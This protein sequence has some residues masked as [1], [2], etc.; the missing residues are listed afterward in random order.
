M[1]DKKHIDRLFQEKFKD[2]EAKPNANVWVNIQSQLNGSKSKDKVIPLWI[3]FAGIAALLML[4]FGLGNSFLANSTTEEN[5]KTVVETTTNEASKTL[6]NL[7]NKNTTNNT[8]DE[9]NLINTKASNKA[10]NTSGTVLQEDNSVNNSNISKNNNNNKTIAN[11]KVSNKALIIIDNSVAEGN[12]KNSKSDTSR[13]DITNKNTVITQKTI[14]QKNKNTVANLNNTPSQLASSNNTA[15]QQKLNTTIATQQPLVTNNPQSNTVLQEIAEKVTKNTKL[16]EGTTKKQNTTLD[17]INANQTLEGLAKTNNEKEEEKTNMNPKDEDAQTPNPLEEALANTEDS[18]EKEEETVLNK[19][20][21]NANVAPVYYN[22]FGK[23]SHIHDQFIENEKNGEINTS[24]G[25]NVGYVLNKKL[26]VR[27]G[28][29]KL[30]LSYDTADVIVFENVSNTTSSTPLRSIDFIPTNG[31][32]ISVLSASNLSVQQ[33]A[34]FNSRLNAALSQRLS[35]IE[36]PLELEYK[37]INKRVGINLIAGLST[38][39]LDGNDVVTELEGR[40][41]KIGEANN[42]NNVSFTTNFG[43]GI[44]YKFSDTFKFN[45]EPTFKYQVNA[46]NETF[47]NFNPYIIGVYTGFSYKF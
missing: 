32:T 8:V 45:I 7:I 30:N 19:W 6:D 38:L 43:F 42:I 10:L 47:G 12:S 26:K 14:Q 17:K 29:N 18:I 9:N 25:I 28:I 21:V 31:E 3:K 44:D 11:T 22:S 1:S 13:N 33:V 5:T 15:Q 35:Y 23:G 2:F 46:Y 4:L 36:V 34:F 41:T 40:K 39:I 27:S 20:T 24:Y 16:E 37:I